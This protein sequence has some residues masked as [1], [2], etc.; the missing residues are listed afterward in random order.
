MALWSAPIVIPSVTF[1]LTYNQNRKSEH[2]R[3]AREIRDD[4]NDQMTSYD[5]FRLE[6]GDYP[7]KGTL[8][9]KFNWIVEL[10]RILIAA[11][12]ALRYFTF[13]IKRKEIKDPNILDYYRDANLKNLNDIDNK[14]QLIETEM[15][16]DAKLE[17]ELSGVL[18]SDPS[19]AVA[20]IHLELS[21]AKEVWEHSTKI[22]TLYKIIYKKGG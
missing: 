11:R 18:T 17:K 8:D 22:R 9:E 7:D 1:V 4:I 16:R 5:K 13:L 20:K 10:H 19:S 12:A 2:I 6:R 21:E 3:M 15:K 14:Y